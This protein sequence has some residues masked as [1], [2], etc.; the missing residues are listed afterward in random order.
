MGLKAFLVK[1]LPQIRIAQNSSESGA[2]RRSVAVGDQFNP[3]LC[4]RC[5]LRSASITNYWESTSNPGQCAPAPWIEQ[6]TDAQHHVR[7]LERPPHAVRVLNAPIQNLSRDCLEGQLDFFVG[8][9]CSSAKKNDP[10]FHSI[11]RTYFGRR[12]NIAE[13]SM[14][15]GS[16]TQAVDRNS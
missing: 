10:Q 5:V 7:T 12:R 15:I 16:I 2:K 4:D 6:S 9:R 8:F 13:L 11:C 1:L 14:K 3:R